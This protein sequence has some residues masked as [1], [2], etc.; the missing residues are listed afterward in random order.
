MPEYQITEISD[1]DEDNLIF[2]Q[3]EEVGAKDGRGLGFQR[4]RK[5]HAFWVSQLGK[6]FEGTFND[7]DDLGKIVDL[8]NGLDRVS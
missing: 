1:D 4:P 7:D 3:A 8:L 2:I 6:K 5:E